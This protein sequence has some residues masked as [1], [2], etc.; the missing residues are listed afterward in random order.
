MHL[1]NATP[2]TTFEILAMQICSVK[3]SR[4][5]KGC[6]QAVSL[7]WSSSTVVLDIEPSVQPLWK[8]ARTR[9]ETERVLDTS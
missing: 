5:S 3:N 2:Y 7:F 1:K 9:V 6:S 8:R 4:L